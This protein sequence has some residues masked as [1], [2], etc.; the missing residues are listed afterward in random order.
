MRELG[1]LSLSR[2]KGEP[3][4]C[5]LA[6]LHTLASGRRS[7]FTCC[8]IAVSPRSPGVMAGQDG[9]QKPACGAEAPAAPQLRP[10]TVFFDG[11]FICAG[12]ASISGN[13]ETSLQQIQ[14]VP[15]SAF[16]FIHSVAS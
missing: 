6:F 11:I 1:N 16:V 12:F 13:P 5:L 14:L 4:H 8:F 10:E 7:Y 3:K 9:E 15:I 2:R